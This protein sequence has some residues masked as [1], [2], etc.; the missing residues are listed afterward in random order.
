MCLTAA[1]LRGQKR[2]LDSLSWSYRQIVC[3]KTWR[4]KVKPSVSDVTSFRHACM[5][6]EDFTRNP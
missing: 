1:V 4:P 6:L 3:M 2:T 5:R